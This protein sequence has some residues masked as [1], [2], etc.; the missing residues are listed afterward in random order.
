M[1]TV[2]V[3]GIWKRFLLWGTVHKFSKDM[4][5]AVPAFIASVKVPHG[6]YYHQYE[7][8]IAYYSSWIAAV[9]AD[10]PTAF[11]A[12]IEILEKLQDDSVN[13]HKTAAQRHVASCCL[14]E[15]KARI[16]SIGVHCIYL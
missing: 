6:I 5:Q 2:E 13:Y 8:S 9:V 16:Q 14:A 3:N 4:Q 11:L 1:V 10:S 7:L 12:C 15:L